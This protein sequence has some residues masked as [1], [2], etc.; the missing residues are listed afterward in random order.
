MYSLILMLTPNI[1]KK[2][3]ADKE[4]MI[5]AHRQEREELMEQI[6]SLQEENA[7]YLETIVQRSKENADQN[8]GRLGTS[9]SQE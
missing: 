8:L 9:P 3:R 1:I 4:D 6:A 2:L 5:E 7:K